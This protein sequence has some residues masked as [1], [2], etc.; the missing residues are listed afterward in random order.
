MLTAQPQR[1][2]EW[3]KI[4]E[5]LGW[6]RFKRSPHTAQHREV[7]GKSVVFVT[8]MGWLFYFMFKMTYLVNFIK[9]EFDG[10]IISW[11]PGSV[12]LLK[13]WWVIHSEGFRPTC[14]D[15]DCQR[16]DGFPR[17][18]ASQ[19]PRLLPQDL[20]LQPPV[21]AGGSFSAPLPP[22]KADP[23]ASCTTAACHL[24]VQLVRSQ[25]V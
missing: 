17:T 1:E 20:S 15:V 8:R 22:A 23:L 19:K 2:G 9:I 24:R 18:G 3:K 25:L 5:S 12:W 16:T 11:A 13:P 14:K 6:W 4:E 7:H 21:P 10:H